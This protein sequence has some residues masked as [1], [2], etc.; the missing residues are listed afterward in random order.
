MKRILL[1][2]CYVSILFSCSKKYENI[3]SINKK[4]TIETNS[5]PYLL[6]YENKQKI[7]KLLDNAIINGDTISY[8]EAYKDFIVSDNSQEFLYYSI[9]M[10]KRNNYS[11][12]YFDTY[13]ILNLLDKKNG[14]VSESDNKEALF[15]LLKAFE[16]GDINAKYKLNDLYIKKNTKI[17]SSA[18]VSN[19]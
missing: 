13:S 9:K 3:S 14:Y 8:Q 17:P 16:K 10:A 1:I 2:P 7:K 18:S 15:Y 19:E 5:N 11:R 12:A 6:N 4:D